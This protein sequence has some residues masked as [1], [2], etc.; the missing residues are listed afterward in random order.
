MKYERD[1]EHTLS[2]YLSGGYS[3]YRADQKSNKGAPGKFCLMPQGQN[4]L[5][6][7]KDQ[8]ELVHLYFSDTQLKRYAATHLEIDARQVDL[9]DLVYQTDVRLE[10]L[11]KSYV[12]GLLTEPATN[13]LSWEQLL[14]NIFCHLITHYAGCDP[15]GP[16]L[17][18]G[19][20]LSHRKRVLD[21][22]HENMQ[23]KITI[24]ILAKQVNISPYH[25]AHLFKQSFAQ[26]P[27]NFVI[28][29][30]IEKAKLLLASQE[31]INS[32]AMLTGFNPVS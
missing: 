3:T 20:S 14:G 7:V 1:S 6:Y 18:N 16:I 24:E 32:I 5:W 29:R 9:R 13:Y 22:I 26:S 19:L 27:A 8:L 30:R 21:Y 11:F 15:K 12:K 23:E 17:K 2:L 28:S 4:S 10:K 31:N 25:F